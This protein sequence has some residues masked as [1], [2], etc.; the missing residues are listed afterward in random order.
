MIFIGDVRASGSL[1]ATVRPVKKEAHE[2]HEGHEGKRDG[3]VHTHQSLLFFVS[4]V[5]F[6]AS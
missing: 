3:G 4:F 5:S 2:G 1:A 6:V